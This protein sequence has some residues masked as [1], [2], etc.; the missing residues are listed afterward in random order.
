MRRV[1]TLGMCGLLATGGAGAALAASPPKASL[2]HFGCRTSS[3]YRSRSI[4]VRAVMRA[5]SYPARMALRFELLFRTS[6]NAYWTSLQGGDLGRWRHPT[7]PPTLGARPDDVWRLTKTVS[8]LNAR[9][10]YRF[11]VTFRWTDTQSGAK[12]KTTLLSPG[13]R[14]GKAK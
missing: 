14:E 13:C 8:N 3:A 1:L 11:R 9:G 2:D 5:Q 4:S 12:K 10:T 6:S 7:N